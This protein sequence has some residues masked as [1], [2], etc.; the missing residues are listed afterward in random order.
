[1]LDIQWIRDNPT[2]FTDALRHRNADAPEATLHAVLELDK[3]RREAV[4]RLQELQT[5]RNANAKAVGP[6]MGQLNK[7]GG[8]L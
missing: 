1:M 4:T 3:A 5:Q 2:A 8:S 7:Q 6:K